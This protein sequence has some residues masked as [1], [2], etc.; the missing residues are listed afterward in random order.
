MFKYVLSYFFKSKGAWAFIVLSLF[1]YLATIAA[2][3]LNGIFL[4][5]LIYNSNVERVVGFALV[6]ALINI[7]GV[8]LNYFANMTNIKV[9]TRTSYA[10][11]VNLVERYE[12]AEL[13]FTETLNS[14]YVTQRAF[15]DVGV[16]SKFVIGSF[17]N[18]PMRSILALGIVAFFVIL[19]PIFAIFSVLLVVIYFVV[20]T[21]MKKPLYETVKE[22]KE[23]D[24][25]FFEAIHSQ[26]SGVFDIQLNAKYNK[27]VLFL[28]SAFDSYYPTTV[29]SC[30]ISNLLSSADGIVSAVF[31]AALLVI[32]GIQIIEGSMTV[33]EYTMVSAYFSML[34]GCA[35]YFM[36][37]FQQCQDASA[38][39]DRMSEMAEYE[40]RPSGSR[41]VEKIET[42][43]VS[44]LRFSFNG[45]NGEKIVF[46]NLSCAFRPCT[47]YAIV[48]EN[49][50]GKS[51]LLKL[52]TGLYDPGDAIAYNGISLNCLDR[53]TFLTKTASVVPQQLYVSP[54]TV[55]NYIEECL[56]DDS[57]PRLLGSGRSE[58]AQYSDQVSQLLD[59][60][61]NTLSGGELRKL[62]LWIAANRSHQILILDEPSTG[63]DAHAKEALCKYVRKNS[64]R[65]IIILMTHDKDLILSSQIVLDLG[66]ITA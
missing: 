27:S 37:I 39:F 18:I 40:S 1:G 57:I 2:P 65:N 62:S 59:E 19:N 56:G 45:E 48:G 50:S 4:D 60:Q 3:Y 11:L 53:E 21:R 20:F 17:L 29:R 52:L 46:R 16:T 33:G 49:G 31:Q 64:A 38:S 54:G 63:L 12:H 30:R 41:I 5:F 9:A 15:T 6:V 66:Q 14:S 24:S 25:S 26:I 13:A 34:L 22:K 28:N 42:L 51:T 23:A 35:K 44:N 61:C 36:G 58:L 47:T 10:M 8:A 32:A 43:S 55:R 7:L